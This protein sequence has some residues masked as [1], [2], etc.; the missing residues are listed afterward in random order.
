MSYCLKMRIF[1][2]GSVIGL[3]SCKDQ[4]ADPN[5]NP[6]VFPASNVSFSQHVQPLFQSRCSFS[7][8]HAGNNPAGG[9]DL[10]SPSYNSLMNHQ[11]R[12]VTSGASSNSLLIQRLDGR[13]APQMP[14]NATPINGN[15]LTGMKKWIDE[16]SQNN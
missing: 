14:F 4:I 10:S 5:T 7:G 16:G 2:I 8:C 1:L 15:Q 13:I 6:V 9:L 11:P 12:L 3:S